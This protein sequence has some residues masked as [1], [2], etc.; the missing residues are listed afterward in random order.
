MDEVILI[1]GI[2]FKSHVLGRLPFQ[3]V[4][5]LFESIGNN[6]PLATALC[7]PPTCNCVKST[8]W[9]KSCAW[10]GRRRD[11]CPSVLVQFIPSFH[12]MRYSIPLF[13][14]ITVAAL[15]ICVV[16]LLLISGVAPCKCTEIFLYSRVT[17]NVGP[18]TAASMAVSNIRR[19]S[20]CM[21][22]HSTVGLCDRRIDCIIPFL[23]MISSE[24][25]IMFEL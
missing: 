18:N 4:R 17:L 20:G 3:K 9:W 7:L 21:P 6:M 8:S 24:L 11:Y 23:F 5:T 25:L 15:H 2:F 10:R 13:S 12:S 19:C 22:F 1:V 14:C 16:F